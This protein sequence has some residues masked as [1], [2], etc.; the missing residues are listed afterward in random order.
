MGSGLD[1]ETARAGRSAIPDEEIRILAMRVADAREWVARD[2]VALGYAVLLRGLIHAEQRLIDGE[3]WAPSLV[4]CWRE[5][6]DDFC[7]RYDPQT[8]DE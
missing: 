2:K 6:I 1:R 8:D 5:V 3:P 4:A 7:A